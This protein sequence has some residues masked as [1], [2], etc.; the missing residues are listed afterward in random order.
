MDLVLP[1]AD[2]LRLYR[3]FVGS[4]GV[5]GS[6][7]RSFANH[8]GNAYVRSAWSDNPGFVR[9]GTSDIWTFDQ[10]FVDHEYRCIDS[11]QGVTTIIDAGANVGYSSAYFLSRFPEARII[12][13]EPDPENFNALRRNLTPWRE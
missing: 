2:R 4:L 3:K 10:I 13:L 7:E 6:V 11:L 5:R 9:R 8:V 12:A 1:I